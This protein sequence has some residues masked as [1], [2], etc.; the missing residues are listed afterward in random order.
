[1]SSQKYTTK[2]K[3]VY[4]LYR[5]SHH[6]CLKSIRKVIKAD[7]RRKDSPLVI[8]DH[9]LVRYAERF[10]GFDS[11]AAQR[12]ICEENLRARVERLGDGRYPVG[13]ILV[14][15]MNMTVVTVYPAHGREWYEANKK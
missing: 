15:V 5:W 1:M 4:W 8:T 10:R 11:V 7:A 2:E 12:A 9:A 14:V 13:D 6:E 3:I